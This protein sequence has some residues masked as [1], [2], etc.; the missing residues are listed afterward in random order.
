MIVDWEVPP[1]WDAVVEGGGKLDNGGF[2][3]DDSVGKRVDSED[4][5]LE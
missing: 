4:G 5:V 1:F 2:L 3:S